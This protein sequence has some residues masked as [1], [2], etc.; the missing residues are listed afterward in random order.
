MTIVYNDVHNIE[1]TLQSVISQTDGRIEYIVVDG[2]STDGT[3]EVVEKYKDKISYIINEPDEGIYDA[4]NKGINIASG[5]YINFM[6]SGDRFVSNETVARIFQNIKN[7]I[8]FIYGDAFFVFSERIEKRKATSLDEV[9]KGMPF[10]HQSLFVKR[11]IMATYKFNKTYKSAADYDFVLKL[12]YNH[13]SSQYI[14]MFICYY[15]MDG[16]SATN[17]VQSIKECLKILKLHKVKEPYRRYWLG[18]LVNVY[19]HKVKMKI[20]REL[21]K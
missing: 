7:D 17:Q 1:E 11:V 6:N 5:K 4:M 2:G 3:I 13:F 14:D 10:S 20:R 16:L 9:W 8:D 18:L 21:K 15:S 19:L 12:C